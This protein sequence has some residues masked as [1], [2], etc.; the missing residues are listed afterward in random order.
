MKKFVVINGHRLFI[1]HKVR[2]TSDAE[3]NEIC[4]EGTICTV[5]ALK[6]DGYTLVGLY[7]TKRIPSWGSLDGMVP[8]RQGFWASIDCI[9]DNFSISDTGFEIV[10]PTRFHGRN[11]LGMPCKL[12]N[13]NRDDEIA[14]VELDKNVGGG[15]ADGLGKRGH[16]IVVSTNS[17]ARKKET[18]TIS[19][20]AERGTMK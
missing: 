15:S 14:L 12:I 17:I 11:L 2:A 3:R 13:T 16:C 6:N 9:V 20:S 5:K 4:T 1:G 7:S 18:K 8:P 10:K 19:A